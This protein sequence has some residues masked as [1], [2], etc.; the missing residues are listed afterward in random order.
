MRALKTLKFKPLKI[1]H[2]PVLQAS[3]KEPHS[4]KQPQKSTC[5]AVSSQSSK[6]LLI[7]Y[8]KQSRKTENSKNMLLCLLR[9]KTKNIKTKKIKISCN[10]IALMLWLIAGSVWVVLASVSLSQCHINLQEKLHQNST[11]RNRFISDNPGISLRR[12]CVGMSGRSY[13]CYLALF[14]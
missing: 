5:R 13:L 7:L 6:L 8:W 11:N 2:K 10:K 12:N 4:T 3:Y 9:E 1:L 14:K